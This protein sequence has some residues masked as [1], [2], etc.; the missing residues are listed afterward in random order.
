MR[1]DRR[2][3]GL[4]RLKTKTPNWEIAGGSNC[5]PAGDVS[6]LVTTYGTMVDQV[7]YSGYG[8]PFGLPVGDTD[9]DGDMHSTY[10]STL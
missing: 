3:G 7:R 5:Q 10:L 4:L 9:S 1:L 6:I 8:G 2:C